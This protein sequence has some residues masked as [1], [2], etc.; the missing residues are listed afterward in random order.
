[1]KNIQNKKSAHGANLYADFI[2][3][4][5]Q[6]SKTNRKKIKLSFPVK[7]N[8]LFCSFEHTIASHINKIGFCFF[9]QHRNYYLYDLSF[10]NQKEIWIFYLTLSQRELSRQMGFALLRHGAMKVLVD[11]FPLEGTNHDA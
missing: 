2:S 7:A 3:S 9:L 10:C 5:N 4:N 1:M 11:F 6:Y 8:P